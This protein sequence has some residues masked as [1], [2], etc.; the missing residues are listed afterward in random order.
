MPQWEMNGEATGEGTAKDA[1][2]GQ[3]LPQLENLK[4]DSCLACKE[5][6][7]HKAASDAGLGFRVRERA[8]QAKRATHGQALLRLLTCSIQVSG[9]RPTADRQLT[10]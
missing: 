3:P 9:S 1:A 10:G 6:Q 5:T 4:S 8:R 2:H 7:G